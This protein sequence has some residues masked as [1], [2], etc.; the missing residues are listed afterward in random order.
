LGVNE[1]RKQSAGEN[2]L[3]TII[4]VLF[5]SFF[6]SPLWAVLM[7]MLVMFIGVTGIINQ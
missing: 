3:G 4:D 7:G 2:I 6:S 1:I 5:G